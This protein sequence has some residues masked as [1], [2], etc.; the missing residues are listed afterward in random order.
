MKNEQLGAD[1]EGVVQ[2]CEDEARRRQSRFGA[3]W[4]FLSNGT[5][6]VARQIGVRQINNLLTVVDPVFRGDQPGVGNDVVE[7]GGGSCTGI[8][9]IIHL[10]GR[11]PGRKYFGPSFAR[12]PIQVDSDIGLQIAKHGPDLGVA[13]DPRIDKSVESGLDPSAHRA[14]VIWPQRDRGSFETCPVM[15]LEATCYRVRHNMFTEIRRD[16]GDADFVVAIA[17]AAPQRLY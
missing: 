17:F 1:L 8:S 12:I 3:A 10:H 5:L 9:E 13:H 11:R 15:M 6:P 16:V 2:A 14:S 7:E 4:F